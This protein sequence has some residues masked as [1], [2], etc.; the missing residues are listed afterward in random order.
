VGKA[1][2]R[3]MLDAFTDN[4]KAGFLTALH[5]DG[6]RLCLTTPAREGQVGMTDDLRD[7]TVYRITGDDIED[8]ADE[9]GVKLTEVEVVHVQKGI[10][11]G[12]GSSWHDI[13]ESAI[14]DVIASRKES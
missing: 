3:Q 8:V 7:D 4:V 6:K 9:M 10:E 2:L 5:F 14:D 13:V 12:F 11:A 1:N